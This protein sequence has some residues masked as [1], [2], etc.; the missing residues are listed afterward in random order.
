MLWQLPVPK[1]DAYCVIAARVTVFRVSPNP[2]RPISDEDKERISAAR[3]AYD[4]AYSEYQAAVI[5]AL[6]N[7]AGVRAV[8]EFS[9]LAVSTVHRW[10]KDA[11]V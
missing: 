6:L 8:S 3:S 2:K 4:H 7:G 9:G 11:A 1:L 5:D 10:K